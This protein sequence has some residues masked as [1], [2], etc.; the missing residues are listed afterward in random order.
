[1]TNIHT[2]DS[3]KAKYFYQDVLGLDLLILA[4]ID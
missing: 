3:E 4:H 2:K 1:M